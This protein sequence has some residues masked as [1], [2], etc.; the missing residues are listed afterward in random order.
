MP[1]RVSDRGKVAVLSFSLLCCALL[2][3]AYSSRHPSLARSGV[4]ALSEVVAPVFRG[5]DLVGD[6]VRGAWDHY[7]YLS[8]VSA[9]NEALLKRIDEL[10]GARG[11]FVEQQR[12][13]ARLRA[14]LDLRPVAQL[15]GVT[16]SV[17]GNEPSGWGKVLVVDRGSAQGVRVGMAVV[18][19]TGIV[20]QVIAASSNFSHVLLITDHSSGVDALLQESRAR[21]VVEGLGA[22]FCELKYVPKEIVVRTGDA[23]VTS[24]MDGVFPKGLIIGTVS[25]IAPET[26]TLLQ[27]IELKVAVD[28]E[29][30]EEVLILTGDERVAEREVEVKDLAETGAAVRRRK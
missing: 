16:G 13:N 24:G 9:D 29:R 1:S 26:G 10:E 23:V 19:P 8:G 2:L 3:T 27:K 11:A 17:V 25:K 4:V 20:G 22:S 12:E 21:G 6:A 14:L 5:I 28:L 18:H 7:L 30:I 15:K